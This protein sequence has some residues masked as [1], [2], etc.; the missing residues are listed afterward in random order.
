M[1]LPTFVLASMFCVYN[2]YLQSR[3]LSQHA[4]YA[5]DWVT[6]P[7]FLVGK[8][9]PR[10]ALRHFHQNVGFHVPTVPG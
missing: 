8:C 6:D 5:D 9:P 2:G 4:V 1:P 3:Y 7:R 10:D